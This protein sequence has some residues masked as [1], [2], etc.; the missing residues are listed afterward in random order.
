MS[1]KKFEITPLAKLR[2]DVISFRKELSMGTP[3]DTD[4][5][6]KFFGIIQRYEKFLCE[7]KGIEYKEKNEIDYGS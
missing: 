1:K 4:R 3:S 5:E 6:Q 2:E 7:A